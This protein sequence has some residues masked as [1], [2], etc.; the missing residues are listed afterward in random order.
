MKYKITF[1]TC[2]HLCA[3]DF[4]TRWCGK[5]DTKNLEEVKYLRYFLT[6]DCENCPVKENISCVC[7]TTDTEEFY[8]R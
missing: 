1:D 5:Q 6:C 3:A 2:M 4:N 8:E 7:E